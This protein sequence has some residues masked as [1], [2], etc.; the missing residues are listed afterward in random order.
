MERLNKSKSKEESNSG[1]YLQIEENG[2]NLSVGERQLL[3]ICRATLRK[4]KLVVLDE[5]TSN[6]DVVTEEKIQKMINEEFEGATML[7]IAHRLNTIINSDRIMLLDKG[8]LKEYDTPEN[9]M[10]DPNSRFA[11][12]C[13]ELKKKASAK[14][15]EE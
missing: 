5:A 14:T 15:A 7:T 9:L 13:K 3:C 1:I 11:G 2:K 8:A 6:I 12:L 10:K 4:A